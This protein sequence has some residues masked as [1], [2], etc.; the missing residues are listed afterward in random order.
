PAGVFALERYLESEIH[1]VGPSLA[2][3]IAEHFGED[4]RDILDH[5]PERVREVSG[6]GPKVVAR[7]ITA[8]RDSSGL[9]DLTVFLR[10][11]GIAAGHA[12]RIHKRYGKES[13]EVVR[14]DPYILARTIHG[15]GFRTADLVA[16]KLGI[17]K[18]SIQ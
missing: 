9:R 12:R 6:I 4:L 13:L 1:G 14:R 18:N 17:A 3:R 8:W 11:H 5:T 15:I 16:E 2:H 10:G 7:I